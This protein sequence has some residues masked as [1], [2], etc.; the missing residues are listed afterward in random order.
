[1]ATKDIHH[2]LLLGGDENS[3]LDDDG[4]DDDD[5]ATRVP[6]PPGVPGGAT[7]LLTSEPSWGGFAQSWRL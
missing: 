1:M 3:S 4:G 5:H 7:G 2:G 6:S